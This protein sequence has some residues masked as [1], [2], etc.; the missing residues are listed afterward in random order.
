MRPKQKRPNR[1][2]RTSVTVLVRNEILQGFAWLERWHLA[3]SDLDLFTS[4]WVTAFTGGTLTNLEVAKPYQLNLVSAL[5]RIR[6]SIKN[7]VY[8]FCRIF[9]G[10][11]S[12]FSHFSNQV[13]FVQCIHLL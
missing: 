5:Q 13:C 3:R 1:I 4:L 9:L 6:D 12:C 8:C 11:F 10:K 7:S 2:I